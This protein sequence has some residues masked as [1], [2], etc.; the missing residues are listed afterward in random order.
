MGSATVTGSSN[1]AVG[2]AAMTSLS[3][4]SNNTAIGHDAGRSGSPGGNITS[5]SNRF[6]LGD[7]NVS[8]LNAQVALTVAS[9]ERDKTAFV[10]LDLGLDFIKEL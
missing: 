3:S 1:T 2:N 10:D 5:G 4:G 9:D 6:S 8:T 7:E